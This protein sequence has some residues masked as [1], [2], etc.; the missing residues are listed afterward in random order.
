MKLVQ[1]V[2]LGI[3]IFQ[4]GIAQAVVG[5]ADDFATDVR[6]EETAGSSLGP[7]E[8]EVETSSLPSS[9]KEFDEAGGEDIVDGSSIDGDDKPEI[10]PN[11]AKR[12]ELE[13]K[14]NKFCD[15]KIKS[16]KLFHS[17]EDCVNDTVYAAR[18]C[19]R[20]GDGKVNLSTDDPYLQGS[21]VYE[22]CMS[23]M[24]FSED[25]NHER[26]ESK[27]EA[28]VEKFSKGAASCQDTV[29]AYSYFEDKEKL[30]ELTA[31]EQKEY[32]RIQRALSISGCSKVVVRAGMPMLQEEESKPQFKC[33]NTEFTFDRRS[34]NNY[35]QCGRKM[36]N[37]LAAV[38]NYDIDYGALGVSKKTVGLTT[39]NAGQL[40]GDGFA[41]LKPATERAKLGNLI[42]H[43]QVDSKGFFGTRF[44]R[45]YVDQKPKVATWRK[46]RSLQ[47]I[48]QKNRGR[49]HGASCFVPAGKKKALFD[50]IDRTVSNGNPGMSTDGNVQA[51]S[52]GV[53]A[54]ANGNVPLPGNNGTAPSGA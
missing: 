23:C 37:G 14:I 20:F 18:V 39:I 12:K 7:A 6:K 38:L 51:G 54:S 45:V 34:N 27:A 11:D 28:R 52:N 46:A 36:R 9:M 10:D 16:S 42:D 19:Q 5:P 8:P 30:G 1:T 53:S 15:A 31:S 3:L 22:Q 44:Y 40:Q 41:T 26:Y 50:F 33:V 13:D 43:V 25:Y 49:D 2:S 21:T 24:V 4:V 47:V 32:R 35:L 48:M 29:M 17:K